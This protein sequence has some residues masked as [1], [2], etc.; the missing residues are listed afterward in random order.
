MSIFSYKV[1]PQQIAA[2]SRAW[3]DMLDEAAL[4]YRVSNLKEMGRIGVPQNL[5]GMGTGQTPD[6]V[7]VP[8]P[9]PQVQPQLGAVAVPKK[10]PVPMSPEAV[11]EQRAADKAAPPQRLANANLLRAVM[12]AESGGDPLA[13]SPKGAMGRYQVM[14]ATAKNPGFG[15][16]PAADTSAAELDRV[17]KQYL[18][19]M[20][21]RYDGD[22]DR[23]LAAYNWGPGKADKWDG[24]FDTLPTETR[25][26]IM[27]IRA[28]IGSDMLPFEAEEVGR[29]PGVV[30]PEST[31]AP[32]TAQPTPAPAQAG[33]AQPT[34]EATINNKGRERQVPSGVTEQGG[35]A[36]TEIA[37]IE[38]AQP[39]AKMI[40][41][42]APQIG[43]K[44]QNLAEYRRMAE[45]RANF[46]MER[47]NPRYIQEL[48]KLEQTDATLKHLLAQRSLDVLERMNNPSLLNELG[49]AGAGVTVQPRSDG[50]FQMVANG[51]VVDVVTK[52][53]LI[54]RVRNTM[55]Q[56]YAAGI[57][58]A[59]A[60]AATAERTANFELRNT[61][62]LENAKGQFTLAKAQIDNAKFFKGGD[63][64]TYTRDTQGNIYVVE[65]TEAPNENGEMEPVTRLKMVPGAGTGGFSINDYNR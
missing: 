17:G 31:S 3:D 5:P 45:I 4:K 18:G 36:K 51:Q 55:D 29:A 27:K 63:D 58:A 21:E 61:V 32:A 50:K 33:L 34:T 60:A 13:V 59:Q 14:P 25:K 37:D 46:Y 20:L 43:P 19:K 30:P 15:I 16:Q 23:A 47:G 7:Q 12:M 49:Y 57:R 41:T 65:D 38:Q 8:A 48:A 62:I 35:A 2:D 24:S 54:S 22:I 28:Q 64:R 40:V 44:I 1:S 52:G 9:Q 6:V 39:P 10:P 11:S 42:P 26:Y 56:D 53:Q